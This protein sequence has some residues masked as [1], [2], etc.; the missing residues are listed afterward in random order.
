[1]PEEILR[2]R[3]GDGSAERGSVDCQGL[4]VITEVL[5]AES[6]LLPAAAL[7]LCATTSSPSRKRERESSEPRESEGEQERA[8]ESSGRE[9]G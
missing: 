9:R 5:M 8:K 2:R 4:A 6:K 3:G 1:M 7:A